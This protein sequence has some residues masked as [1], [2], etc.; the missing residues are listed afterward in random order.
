MTEHP[1]FPPTDQQLQID[2]L[3]LQLEA[4]HRIQLE[5][6]KLFHK[7]STQGQVLTQ[8]PI[9]TQMEAKGV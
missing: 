7:K 8:Y 3:K 1:P 4:Y 2:Q 5:Q 6:D 9:I